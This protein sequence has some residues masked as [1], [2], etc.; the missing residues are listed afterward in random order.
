M[1]NIN[2]LNATT[3]LAER[4]RDD[5]LL[6]DEWLGHMDK[7][8]DP[9]NKTL[10]EIG[11]RMANSM[12]FRDA[13]ICSATTRMSHETL[14]MF[15]VTPTSKAVGRKIKKN[16]SNAYSDH[17]AGKTAPRTVMNRR[18]WAVNQLLHIEE[19]LSLPNAKAQASAAVGY[20]QW[21]GLGENAQAMESMRR[22]AT[23]TP[24]RLASIVSSAIAKG[25]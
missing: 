16:L 5:A 4:T 14:T 15:V 17:L 18:R 22:S 2:N 10:I 24:V 11:H 20:I 9:D 3:H 1:A 12:A 25:A 13:I 7:G 23:F 21:L 19:S 6:L 8:T